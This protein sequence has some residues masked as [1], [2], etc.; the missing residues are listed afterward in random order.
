MA[1][2]GAAPVA[3]IHI[4]GGEA[5]RSVRMAEAWRALSADAVV[6]DAVQVP[7]T[8]LVGFTVGTL[9]IWFDQ[10]IVT[11]VGVA[12]IVV[13]AIAWPVLARLGFGPKAH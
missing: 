12:A 4:P 2:G 10:N 8:G 3:A 5:E 13:G 6:D 7:G 11:W 9:G 1:V